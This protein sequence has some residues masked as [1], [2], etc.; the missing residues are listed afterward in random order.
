MNS[1]FDV[2][3]SHR[4][5][6]KDIVRKLAIRL[7]DE[8]KLRP[9]FD[10]WHLIPG[11]PLQEQLEVALQGSD[12][13]AAFIGPLGLSPWENEEVRVILKSRIQNKNIRVIPVLLPGADEKTIEKL[14]PLLRRFLWV[15]FREGLDSEQPLARLVAGIQGKPPGR[16]LSQTITNTS[17][18]VTRTTSE[19]FQRFVPFDIRG[20]QIDSRT[21]LNNIVRLV[22]LHN[23]EMNTEE[24]KSQLSKARSLVY[25]TK[26]AQRGT[27][28]DERYIDYRGWQ[29]QFRQ[30]LF[31]CGCRD[32]G[33]LDVINV[34]I[35]NGNENPDFYG[36]F[37]TL[38]GIDISQQSLARAAQEMPFMIPIHGEAED[39]KDIK[40]HSK[41]LYLSLRTYQS[42]YLNITEAIFEAAR[43]LRHRGTAIISIPNVYVDKGRISKGLQKSA[44]TSLDPHFGWELADD[45]RRALHQ[46]EFDAWITKGQFEIFVVG[47]S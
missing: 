45:I 2:F 41:D 7:Q 39:L 5:A 36:E 28:E 22:T 38:T 8:A 18:F 44:G 34:G 37:G 3:L 40:S 17:L 12:S 35:G 47:Q 25:D 9:F 16:G 6:D 23:P 33:R 10:E 27:S 24:V 13:C 43:V 32:F 20:L 4:S 1:E 11:Q 19:L 26:Y 21:P 15:D 42:S 29:N 14:P 31:D 30:L 46:A